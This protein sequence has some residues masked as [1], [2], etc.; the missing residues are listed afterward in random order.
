MSQLIISGIFLSLLMVSFGIMV[1]LILQGLKPD[2][3]ELYYK[4]QL[5]RLEAK[6]K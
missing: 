5:K 1:Y 3:T 2:T 4:L 6:K